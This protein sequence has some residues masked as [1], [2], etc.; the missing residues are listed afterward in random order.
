MIVYIAY[1]NNREEYEDYEEGIVGVFSTL[2]KAKEALNEYCNSDNKYWYPMGISVTEVDGEK[3]EW[4][5][6][7]K[8]K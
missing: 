8:G 5:D 4:I 2:E 3:L 7:E 1:Y 6:L